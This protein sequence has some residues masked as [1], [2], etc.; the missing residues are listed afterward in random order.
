MGNSNGQIYNLKIIKSGNRLEIYKING[1]V[2][3]AN[4]KQKAEKVGCA[5]DQGQ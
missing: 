5:S 3:R 1:Y 2:V 4:T